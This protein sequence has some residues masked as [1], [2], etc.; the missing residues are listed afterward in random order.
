[1]RTYTQ[2]VVAVATQVHAHSLRAHIRTHTRRYRHAIIE[3][4]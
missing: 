2:H 4:T 1:M 3:R